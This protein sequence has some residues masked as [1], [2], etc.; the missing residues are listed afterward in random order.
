MRP[1]QQIDEERNDG[2]RPTS[3]ILLSWLCADT[4][5]RIVDRCI[6][7]GL[8][9]HFPFPAAYRLLC[10]MMPVLQPWV[11][12]LLFATIF[13]SRHYRRCELWK[14]TL[15][16]FSQAIL[17]FNAALLPETKLLGTSHANKEKE[18]HPR[19]NSLTVEYRHT[20]ASRRLGVLRQMPVL[21]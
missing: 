6:A 18:S 21:K 13:L 19:S 9:D 11:L 3:V 12:V 16:F 20:P 14:R 1:K 4:R 17:E 8:G 10:L 7:I 15:F 2:W 5:A